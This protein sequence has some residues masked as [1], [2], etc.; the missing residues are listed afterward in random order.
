MKH[1]LR[2]VLGD[3]HFTYEELL[4]IITRADAY[5]NSCPLT[6]ISS[7]PKDL[8]PL[9]PGHFLIGDSLTAI[10]ETDETY[11]PINRLNRWRRVSQCSQN[12]WK[13]SKEYL[14]RL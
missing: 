14:F 7:D 1:L 12:L 2:R 6:P 9:T 8:N 13:R 10:H 5:L 4:T 3:A 11:L